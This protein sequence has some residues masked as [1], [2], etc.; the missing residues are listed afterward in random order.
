MS[1]RVVNTSDWAFDEI[2]KYGRELTAAFVKLSQTFPD[3]I[4]PQGIFASLNKGEHHLWL[5]LD[6]DRFVSFILTKTHTIDATGKKVVT[7]TSL[8]GEDG[9]ASG[10]AIYS[11]IEKWAVEQG[12]DIGAIEGRFGWKRIAARHGYEMYAVIYRK[13]LTVA[14][15]D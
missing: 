14:S 15:S 2:A 11:E 13:H 10:E 7:I 12:A 3:D 8:A 5:V 9:L 6:E 4:T 1:Y